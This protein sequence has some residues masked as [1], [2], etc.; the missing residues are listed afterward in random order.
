M[1]AQ[2]KPYTINPLNPP[3][4]PKGY[5]PPPNRKIT[6]EQDGWAWD[7]RKIDRKLKRTDNPDE[8]WA[9]LGSVSPGGNLMGAYKNNKPQMTQVNRLLAMQEFNCSLIGQQVR[10]TCGNHRCSNPHHFRIEPIVK[11]KNV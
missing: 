9:W 2:R 3:G 8:C 7:S 5:S 10:M 4:R 6:H 1:T 11:A